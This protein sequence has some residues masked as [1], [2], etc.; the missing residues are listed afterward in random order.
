MKVVGNGDVRSPEDAKKMLDETGCDYVMIGRAACQNPFLFTQINELL[1]KGSY[2]EISFAER[3]KYFFKY[4]DYSKNYPTIQF[5][6][7]RMQAMNFTKGR[8]GGKELRQAI[9]KVKNVDELRRL[10]EK[11]L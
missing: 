3:L 4:L 2:R 5:P 7:I 11:V 10:L 8:E 9:G 1:N 6:N